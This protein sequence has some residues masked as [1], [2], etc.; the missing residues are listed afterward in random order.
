MTAGGGGRGPKMGRGDGG[1]RWMEVEKPG[2]GGGC[3]N[4]GK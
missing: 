1:S 4:G 3:R 2:L